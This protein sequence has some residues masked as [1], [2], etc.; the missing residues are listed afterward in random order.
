MFY[1]A[2][3]STYRNPRRPALLMDTVG[4][5][6]VGHVARVLVQNGFSEGLNTLELRRIT[7]SQSDQPALL[8]LL[9]Y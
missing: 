9:R 6:F 4:I 1:H 7:R 5:S 3:E 2:P 8:R